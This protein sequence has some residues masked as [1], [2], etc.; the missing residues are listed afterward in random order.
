[1]WNTAPS[2]RVGSSGAHPPTVGCSWAVNALRTSHLPGAICG[3]VTR[4]HLQEERQEALGVF[5]DAR[6]RGRRR[7]LC[8]LIGYVKATP[9]DGGKHSARHVASTGELTAVILTSRRPQQRRLLA[10]MGLKGG[11]HRPGCRAGVLVGLNQ[12]RSPGPLVH[13]WFTY[14]PGMPFGSTRHERESVR[15]RKDPEEGLLIASP[16]SCTWSHS[17][18]RSCHLVTRQ[19]S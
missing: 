16:R 3:P 19:V 7:L 11:C 15:S 8:H 9:R 12:P 13:D 18:A 14:G 1:M 5:G 2:R 4:G 10:A 17:W 6:A